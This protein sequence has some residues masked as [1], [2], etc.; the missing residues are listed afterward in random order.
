MKTY[1][2]LL[3]Y[4]FTVLSTSFK[5]NAQNEGPEI[6]ITEIGS[7]QVINC[8]S[9]PVRIGVT[10]ENWRPGFSYLWNTGQTDSVIEVKPSQTAN[11]QL[12]ITNAIEGFFAT[13]SFNVTVLNDP[14]LGTDLSVFIDKFHCPGEP[15]N[16]KPVYSGGHAPFQ[17]KWSEGSTL[18]QITV[19]PLESTDYKLSITDACGT[20]KI[21]TAEVNVEDRDPIVAP[22]L[23]QF[24]FRCEGE[25]IKIYPKLDGI[26]GGV[27]YGYVYSFSDWSQ[28]N[29]SIIVSAMDAALYEVKVTDAC[30]IDVTTTNIEL[31]KQALVQPKLND[32]SVCQGAEAEITESDS[33]EF[34]YWNGK[35]MLMAHTKPIEQNERV[36]LVYIDA[37]G[38]QQSL[39][40]ELIAQQV[41]AD[42]T[43]TIFEIDQK[44]YLSAADPSAENLYEWSSNG[45]Y[46]GNT[47][48]L[49]ILME[50]DTE[51][52]VSLAV[53][54]KNGCVNTTTR[55][56]VIP[57]NIPIAT[58]FSPNGDGDNDVFSVDIQDELSIFQIKIFNRWGQLVYES[59]DQYFKWQGPEYVFS[60]L[61]TY[62][63]KLNGITKSGNLIE[64]SGTVSVVN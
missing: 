44:I 32:I 19:S 29:K 53:M 45:K 15:L 22:S 16:L 26:S 63:F 52:E 60:Q 27:G 56:A 21:I 6:L 48:D 31:V 61:D 37:C 28:P 36:E 14:I 62:A 30:K 49:E 42:F 47:K 64:K 58:A 43:T 59:S 34:F 23:T 20:E 8:T 38:E 33:G 9:S 51:I 41:D 24:D 13:R 17:F 46:L 57:S 10:I 40:R 1:L 50:S 7:N 2:A 35:E 25:M 12:T 4:T 54:N 55:T 18:N 3:I 11:F 39:W 5:L